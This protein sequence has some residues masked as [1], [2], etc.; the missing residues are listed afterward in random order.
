[1]TRVVEKKCVFSPA[2]SRQAHNFA[3]VSVTPIAGIVLRKHNNQAQSLVLTPADT[4]LVRLA[5]WL[6]AQR[7]C[8]N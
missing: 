7:A 8:F 5:L 6:E 2:F 1:M 4:H 3:R